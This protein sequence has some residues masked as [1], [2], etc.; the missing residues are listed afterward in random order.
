MY[1]YIHTQ[2]PNLLIGGKCLA[3]SCSNLNVHARRKIHERNYHFRDIIRHRDPSPEVACKELVKWQNVTCFSFQPLHE[4]SIS[5]QSHCDSRNPSNQKTKTKLTY[6]KETSRYQ[7]ILGKNTSKPRQLCDVFDA[8]VP[9]STYLTIPNP[10]VSRLPE[11]LRIG[12]G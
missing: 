5:K 1:I 4:P 12:R 6:E 10:G 2:L 7:Y 8:I 11:S 9:K 3:V